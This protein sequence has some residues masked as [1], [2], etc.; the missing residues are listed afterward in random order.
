[1]KFNKIGVIGKFGS[2][3]IEPT[4]VDLRKILLAEN[5]EVMF[6]TKISEHYPKQNFNSTDKLYLAENCDLVIVVGG[7]GS[8]L[9]A[10]RFMSPWKKPM[11]GIN[12]GRLGFL[13]DITPT[14]METCLKDILNGE[15]ESEIRFML[16]AKIIRNAKVIGEGLAMND[17]V[18]HKWGSARMIEFE[19]IINDEFV[20]NQRADGIV[21]S[22]PTG[23]TAYALSGGGPIMEPSL[24]AIT[25]V[26]ICPHT[27]SNRPLVV[28]SDNKIELIIVDNHGDIGQVSYDGQ[29]NMEVLAGDVVEIVRPDYHIELVHPKTHTVY[30]VLREKLGWGGL[31]KNQAD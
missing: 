1:M 19:T 16:Q 24:D 4:L 8:F 28:R 27:L 20:N 23:S 21:V 5:L 13:T 6:E 10:A 31:P 9:D 18:L 12:L 7:D 26:S 11:L 3:D 14:S 17:V 22:T 29:I 25:L 2:Q 15:Y 30:G